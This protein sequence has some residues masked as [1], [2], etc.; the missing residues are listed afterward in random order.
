MLNSRKLWRN[1]GKKTQ[2]LDELIAAQSPRVWIVADDLT[3]ADNSRI[4]SF[5]DRCG[6]VYS[7][8]TYGNRP[9]L[10]T[11]SW[12][13]H[14]AIKFG[15]S[16]TTA[17]M[18]CADSAAYINGDFTLF[19]VFQKN[20]EASVQYITSA[21]NTGTFVNHLYLS[22]TVGLLDYTVAADVKSTQ[23]VIGLGKKVVVID[24][25]A[26]RINAVAATLYGSSFISKCYMTYIG[27]ILNNLT[28]S[29]FDG[30]LAYAVLLP[31]RF[32]ENK[33]YI[34]QQLISQY[35]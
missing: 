19:L 20:D 13:N 31:G 26:I 21:Y 1:L 8:S 33:A 22:A 14:Q 27:S 9:K 10:S 18:L 30:Y 35:I 4:A 15:D 2:T 34:E 5:T 32:D 29:R 6:N 11:S 28:G 16:G 25:D 7:Q 3:G 12:P 23:Q 17:Y 24:N